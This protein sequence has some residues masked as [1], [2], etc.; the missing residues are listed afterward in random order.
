MSK[1]EAQITLPL[2][3]FI[4]IDNKAQLLDNLVWDN[5]IDLDDLKVYEKDT[6]YQIPIEELYKPREWG[7]SYEN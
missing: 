3:W 2:D 4:K 5:V 1:K 7:T 6:G